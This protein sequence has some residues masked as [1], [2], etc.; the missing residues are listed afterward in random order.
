MLKQPGLFQNSFE[1][2]PV[3]IA[4]KHARTFGRPGRTF[5]S[6][7]KLSITWLSEEIEYAAARSDFDEV[8][9]LG[10]A[11]FIHS[12]LAKSHDEHI[13][14]TVAFVRT[15]TLL[16]NEQ[17]RIHDSSLTDTYNGQVQN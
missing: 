14:G 16:V 17:L 2:D 1:I 10:M 12:T 9:N 4:E 5:E 11:A 8:S 7:L 13:I 15:N 6:A 3:L